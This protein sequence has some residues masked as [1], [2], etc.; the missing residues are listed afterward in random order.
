MEDETTAMYV[1][2]DRVVLGGVSGSLEI[3]CTNYINVKHRLRLKCGVLSI[4]KDPRDQ[5][6]FVSTGDGKLLIITATAK[7][8]KR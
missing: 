8:F 5:H 2:K 7:P 6:L 3:R 1:D 4:S